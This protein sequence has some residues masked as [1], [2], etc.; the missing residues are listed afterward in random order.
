MNSND[1]YSYLCRA[2]VHIKQENYEGAINDFTKAIDL[3]KDPNSSYQAYFQR[4]NCYRDLK[5]YDKSIQDLLKACDNKNNDADTFH[6]LGMSYL[7]NQE[8]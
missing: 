7:E 6:S 3:L 8:Y 2:K 4:G 5:M 1:G